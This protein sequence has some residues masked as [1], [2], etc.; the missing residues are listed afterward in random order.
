MAVASAGRRKPYRITGD[1]RDALREE[2]A[3]LVRSRPARPRTALGPCGRARRST[4]RGG[5]RGGVSA[6]ALV[7][8]IALGRRRAVP[9]LQEIY[10]RPQP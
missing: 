5:V 9:E 8:V 4:W 10:I 6:G 3:D 2:V 1:G 7:A